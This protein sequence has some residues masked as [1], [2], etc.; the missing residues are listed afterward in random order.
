MFREDSLF[1]QD[2][3]NWDIG[4]DTNTSYMFY[5]AII[6]NYPV[7]SWDVSSLKKAELMFGNAISF[8]QSLGNWNL[9]Q[10]VNLQNSLSQCGLDCSN[11]SSTLVGWNSNPNTPDSINLGLVSLHYGMNVQSD[12]DNLIN[13]KGWIILGDTLSNTNCC[14]VQHTMLTQTS[15]QYYFFNGQNLTTSGTYYDTLLNVNGCDSIISLNLT[16]NQVNTSMTQSGANLS[17]NASAANYQWLSCNPYQIISGATNQTFTANANGDYAVIVT[18]NG[19]TDTS[20][21]ITV[22]GIGL[23]EYSNDDKIIVYPNPAQD[24]IY[25]TSTLSDNQNTKKELYNTLGQ[26]ILTTYENEIDVSGLV[27]GV[28]YIRCGQFVEK[29]IVE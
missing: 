1:N 27:K 9:P 7:F 15:C 17:A 13:I 11:Y 19:C 4:S 16:I 26:V 21:C 23:D 6:F 25:V 3:S 8:N 14:V 28:Y 10:H 5:S 24:R 12:H 29:V 2:L 18:E 20:A 22:M